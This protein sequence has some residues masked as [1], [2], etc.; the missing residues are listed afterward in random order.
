MNLAELKDVDLQPLWVEGID[1]KLALKH[2]LLFA[3]V[4]SQ[5][6]GIMERTTLTT[7]LNHLS[8]LELDYGLYLVDDESFVRL[9][10]KFLERQTGDSF[11]ANVYDF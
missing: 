10:D 4:E 5:S 7:A 11:D 2:S 1:H 3:T 6:V 8:T 9:R